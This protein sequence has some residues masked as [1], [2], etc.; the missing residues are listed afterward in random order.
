[1]DKDQRDGGRESQNTVECECQE[2]EGRD[3]DCV[4]EREGVNMFVRKRERE[5]GGVKKS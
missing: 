5:R 3:T 2:L 1:M 4:C